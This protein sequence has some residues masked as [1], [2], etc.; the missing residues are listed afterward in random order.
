MSGHKETA[1]A[2]VP[3]MASDVNRNQV[4]LAAAVIPTVL[5][6]FMYNAFV[7]LRFTLATVAVTSFGFWISYSLIY[8][9]LTHVTFARAPAAD[10]RAWLRATT[11]KRRAQRIET[12]LSGGGPSANAHWSVLAMISVAL[13]WLT[14]GLLDSVVANVLAF[15]V[16]AS[17]WTVTV[18][19]YTVHYAR[20]DAA[21]PSLQFPGDGAP[22][23]ADYF[24]LSAQVATTFSSS[25]VSIL[26]TLGRRVVTGQTIIA[27]VF[28]TFIIAML[29]AVIFLNN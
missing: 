26:T 29:L 15:L 28:S 5:G 12:A 2:P 3:A 10:L 4:A 22:V 1:S 8:L 23:F 16:V 19:A 6:F 14:P 17:A 7:P 9:V 24:Y 25:D 18:Y 13:V 20:L 27:F 11:P 21:S